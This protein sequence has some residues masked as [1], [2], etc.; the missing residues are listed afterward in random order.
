MLTK[1]GGRSLL[2]ILLLLT[3]LII[4]ANA[5]RLPTIGGDDG[6]WGTV[7]NAFLSLEHKDDGS[8]GNITA[9]SVN[10]S[11]N[12]N[13]TGGLVVG[14]NVTISGPNPWIDV[15]AYGAKGDGVTDDADAIQS[16]IDDGIT[17][18]AKV[19]IPRGTYVISKQINVSL[20]SFASSKAL[21][22]TGDWPIILANASMKTVIYIDT[23]AY[24]RMERIIVDA[25][26]NATYGIIAHKLTSRNGIL[27]DLRIINA[28]SD[29]LFANQSQ[30]SIFRNIVSEN[31][32]GSGFHIIDGNGLVLEKTS[33]NTNN[34]SGYLIEGDV[35]SG[36]MWLRDVD[37]ELNQ[38][39]GIEL[40]RMVQ[41]GPI[42]DG[43]WLEGNV[44]DGVFVNSS[45][46]V[47]TNLNIIGNPLNANKAVRITTYANGTRVI[48]NTFTDDNFSVSSIYRTIRDRSGINSSYIAGNTYLLAGN[49]RQLTLTAF[50][51]QTCPVSTVCI[52][53]YDNETG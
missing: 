43:G 51:N 20:G 47:V 50:N 24:F 5:E 49:V 19:Y 35:N 38:G 11:G 9:D 15:K 12:V 29:G 10:V 17:H 3:A 37:A 39:N 7:L 33:S 13:I 34:G 48:G 45:N 31:N 41:G 44:L 6:D 42:I 4:V 30:L 8:H 28:K 1:G 32:N 22:I 53:Q 46:T 23:A 36:K 16:A 26:G 2:M 52:E 14:K 40:T 27:E 18:R 25:N 21:T